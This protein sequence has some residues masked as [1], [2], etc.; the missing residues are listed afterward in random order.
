MKNFFMP[1]GI[2]VILYL[3]NLS[4]YLNFIPMNY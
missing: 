4:Y 1:H 3:N 2:F